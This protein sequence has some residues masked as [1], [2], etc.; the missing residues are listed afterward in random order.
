LFNIK[1]SKPHRSN[2]YTRFPSSVQLVIERERERK[3]DGF[4][5]VAAEEASLFSLK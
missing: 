3:R 5:G 4:S 1:C 2:P